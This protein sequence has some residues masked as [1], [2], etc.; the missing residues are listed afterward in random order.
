MARRA[1]KHGW[2]LAAALVAGCGD[3]RV[4]IDAGPDGGTPRLA[5]RFEPIELEGGAPLAITEI[6]FVPGTA[7]FLAL[8]KSRTVTL[9][10]LDGDRAIRIGE[11][12]VPG[13]DD[14]ADCGLLSVAFDPEFADNQLVY[15]AACESTQYSFISRHR[16]DP[17][18]L[19][20]IAATASP[21]I[22][23][24]ADDATEAWH[25]IGSIGF[26]RDG[27]LWALF[28]DKNRS[29][30][31]QDVSTNLGAVIRI[32]PERVEAGYQPAPGNP[33]AGVAGHSPDLV[34]KGL[35]SPWRGALDHAGRLWIGDVGNSMFE[36]VNVS[37]FAGENFGASIVEGACTESCDA[38]TDPVVTWDRSS[39]HRYA[40]EDP[41]A[42]AT[43]RRVVWVGVDYPRTV[44]VDRYQGRLFEK[45]LVG[46]F[47]TGWIR[48]IGLDD[49][50]AVI[51]DEAAGHL[52][53]ATSWTVGPDGYVYASSYG[54]CL[55]WPY[56]AGAVHRAVLDE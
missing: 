12:D 44:T 4:S 18:D 35:R 21:V 9:F 51:H 10:R 34:A 45:M 14:R 56:R 15:F 52:A 39:G 26:D 20:S 49:D 36:E 47:C 30:R 28:G 22:R 8:T 3:N 38:L 31:A 13:V 24:G 41:D 6:A 19:G 16:F 46:D 11:L 33:F 25:N 23:V 17:D 50:G 55:A 37:R 53:A 42:S 27:Y 32:A 5:L 54:S 43:T 2:L 40:Q 48:A 29:A 1:S 7:D